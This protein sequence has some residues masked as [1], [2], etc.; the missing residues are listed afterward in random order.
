MGFSLVVLQPFSLG[1]HCHD[2][3][4]LWIGFFGK[5]EKF[6][7]SRNVLHDSQSGA[8]FQTI[9][10]RLHEHLSVVIKVVNYVKSSALNTRLLSKLCTDM[11]TNYTAL[12]YQTQ[13]RWLSKGNMFSRIFELREVR[14][15]LVTK[16][17]IDLL[18][19]FGG[20]KFSRYLA[21]HY[22][23]TIH[24]IYSIC[25]CKRRTVNSIFGYSSNLTLMEHQLSTYFDFGTRFPSTTIS[26]LVSMFA[27]A[28]DEVAAMIGCRNSVSKIDCTKSDYFHSTFTWLALLCALLSAG[29][30]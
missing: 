22:F 29:L 24:Y 4:K 20:D 2:S 15:F 26:M 17:K 10:K 27:I 30:H 12:L 6:S 18:L 28:C 7:N 13:V 14:L 16:Q 9:P 8:R 19:A 5:A 21:Y 23:A 25:Q 1:F 3:C 11:V